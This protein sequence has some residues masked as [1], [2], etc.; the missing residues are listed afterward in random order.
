LAA[1]GAALPGTTS[2]APGRF[3]IGSR[4]AARA[5]GSPLPAVGVAAALRLAGIGAGKPDPY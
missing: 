1:D 5:A 3:R 2:A 4:V